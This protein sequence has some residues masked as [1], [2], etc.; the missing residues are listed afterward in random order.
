MLATLAVH[1]R[2]TTLRMRTLAMTDELTGVPNRR[3]VLRR[4]EELLRRRR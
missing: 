3:D 4:L 2:R 1:Q